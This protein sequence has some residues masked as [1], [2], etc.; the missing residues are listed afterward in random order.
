ML[1]PSSACVTGA[2]ASMKIP[3]RM[4][5]TK[6]SA[7]SA[8]IAAS[9]LLSVSRAL[10][11]AGVR[12]RPRKVTPKAFTKQA[13]ASAADNAN[14]APTAGTSNF[15]PQDGSC[16]LS[17]MAWNHSHSDTQPLDDRQPEDA[18]APN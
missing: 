5:A 14:N 13:A 12:G 16:G 6:H 17:R 8:N 15:R 18:Q 4:P 10:A 2:S 1:I 11:A 9:E 3:G 7:A